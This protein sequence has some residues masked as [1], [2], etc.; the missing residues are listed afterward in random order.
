M[1]SRH[2]SDSSAAPQQTAHAVSQPAAVHHSTPMASPSMMPPLPPAG[3]YA[4]PMA[5]HRTPSGTRGGDISSHF[6][7]QEAKR[8]NRIAG[9]PTSGSKSTQSQL[10]MMQASLMQQ[11]NMMMMQ[12]MSQQQQ[13]Y[14]GNQMAWNQLQHIPPHSAEVRVNSF[15][16]PTVS[17]AGGV[18]LS[19][20]N[21]CRCHVPVMVPVIVPAI[22]DR[23][24]YSAS[25]LAP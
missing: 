4:M 8:L 15:C 16:C 14:A 24:V 21:H 20:W 1:T 9:R 17:F 19:R 3:G 11:N 12:M 5:Q 22:A 25:H 7:Q 10:A 23:A 2:R 13:R 6:K 18:A